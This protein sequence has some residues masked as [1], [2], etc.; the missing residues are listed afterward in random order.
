MANTLEVVFEDD[1][2]REWC[3]DLGTT[4][5]PMDD[6]ELCDAIE[7]GEVTSDMRVWRA[8]LDGWTPVE[9]LPELAPVLSAAS[10]RSG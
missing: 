1:E 7:S 8:G 5:T 3:V 4:L 10:S 6:S 9:D 2:P